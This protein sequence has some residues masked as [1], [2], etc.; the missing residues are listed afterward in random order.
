VRVLT[1]NRISIQ[2]FVGRVVPFLAEREVEF[3]LLIG[4]ASRY[5]ALDEVPSDTVWLA[6]ED[7]GALVG[8]ALRTPPHYVTVSELPPGGARAIA[9][10]FLKLGAVPDGASGPDDHGRDV[11]VALSEKLGGKV[12]LRSG[13]L[14][15]ELRAVNDVP[16]P[17]G[18]ARV[19]TAADL[20]LLTG[21]VDAFLREVALPYQTDPAALAERYV[22]TGTALL[23]DDGGVRALACEARRTTTGAAIAPVY[24]VPGS[25]RRGYGAAV[26]A[27]LSRRLLASGNRFVCLFAEQTNPTANHVYQSIGFRR[28]RDFNVWSLR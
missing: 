28:V 22:A 21:H 23:W 19:A 1:V 16:Q 4:L 26:T 18:A 10:F 12:E 20:E 2:E 27:E 9:D 6:L 24:T 5:A 8:A 17:G 11:L 13:E 3:N 14:I 25:R 7:D 15:Y